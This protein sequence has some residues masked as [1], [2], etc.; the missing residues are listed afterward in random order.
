VED[1]LIKMYADQIYKDTISLDG[2][3]T[4]DWLT[5]KIDEYAGGDTRLTDQHRDRIRHLVN[6]S[7][8]VVKAR[9]AGVLATKEDRQNLVTQERL[10]TCDYYWARFKDSITQKL[11]RH[12]A[13][14]IDSDIDRVCLQMPDPNQDADF[15][16]KGMVIGDVQAG[17]TNNYTALINKSADL[18]YRL[19]IVLTGVT[20]PLRS[21]TQIRLDKDF[22]GRKSVADRNMPSHE[23]VG[24]GVLA[25]T[26]AD[27][28]PYSL[29][30]AKLDFLSRNNVSVATQGSPV[31]VVTKKNHHVLTS[32]LRWMES[33][34][35]D[36]T[37]G[38]FEHATLIIDDE[39]DNASVNT[40][41]EGEDPKKINGLIRSILNVCS[42]VSYVAY[43][44]TPFANVFI[45]PDTEDGGLVDLFPSHFIVC[46][47]PPSNYCG[48]RFFYADDDEAF[49]ETAFV[50][51]S[52]Y[53]CE[54][55]I[56][57]KHKSDLK[58][59]AL[60]P[61]MKEALAS[62]F[63]AAAIKDIRREKGLLPRDRERFDSC[64]INVSRFTAVQSDLAK[65][66]K[67]YVDE[68][69]SDGTMGLTHGAHYKLIKKVYDQHYKSVAGVE[70][71]WREV[72]AALRDMEQPE[73]KIVHSKS[74]DELDYGNPTSGSKIVAIGGFK[75][76]RGLT[77]EGLTVSYFYRRSMM[78]D[79]LMQMARWFG[80][81]DGYRDLL[82][83][84]TTP[85]ARD[86]YAHISEATEELKT[87]LLEM[88]GTGLEPKDFGIKVR[89]HEDTLLVTAKNKMRA[90]T[91]IKDKV[92]YANKLKETAF[93]DR[94]PEVNEQNVARV[95][96]FFADRHEAVEKYEI[97]KDSGLPRFYLLNSIPAQE[98]L[99]LLASVNL[100]WG[101]DWARTDR[102]QNYL[103]GHANGVFAEWDIAFQSTNKSNSEN[104][105]LTDQLSIGLQTRMP[106]TL[107]QPRPVGRTMSDRVKYSIALSDNR[108]VATGS[109]DYVGIPARELE[110]SPE[111]RAKGSNARAWKKSNRP[112]PLLVFHLIQL[113]LNGAIER[114]K[115]PKTQKALLD[116]DTREN[117]PFYSQKLEAFLQEV[118]L[119]PYYLALSI[120]IPG[121]DRAADGVDYMISKREYEE[122]FGG[123]EYDE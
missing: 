107:A 19:I 119:A 27:R 105:Q 39:A 3:P 114:L 77:L 28:V 9:A 122:R 45:D 6:E 93:V 79:T 97:N 25:G 31:L 23:D 38:A 74:K 51:R 68:L 16:C 75:L 53:D 62:F 8:K 89:S 18:G 24:V 44:A 32:I 2:S 98:A 37:S 43:T 88:E 70:E 81:R 58:P 115:H 108:K 49:R 123:F 12:V 95:A 48:G 14:S 33:Q 36:S 66:V 102:L 1:L 40:A 116:S 86:W 35:D 56:P 110:V 83:L 4:F 10:D 7:V 71:S 60:P 55:F 118:D 65:P 99:K 5:S 22:V 17:K 94:R 52:I 59:T 87:D 84:Y 67:D 72:A 109:I 42:K 15:L 76:A 85:D 47:H 26:K 64:L 96:G 100:D 63:V 30:D 91:E 120:S 69:W 13:D 46:L 34:R 29:T 78:Y 112:H 104:M 106:F 90:A 111:L 80:Y 101:N 82:R 103:R 20:E 73:V 11:G 92:S 21:Q 41:E 121:N 117:A 57:L 113:D 61:S 54:S 50:R